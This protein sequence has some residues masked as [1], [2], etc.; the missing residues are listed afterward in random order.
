MRSSFFATLSVLVVLASAYPIVEPHSSLVPNTVRLSEGISTR[1]GPLSNSKI[2]RGLL[3]DFTDDRKHE[4]INVEGEFHDV[5]ENIKFDL[6]TK[7]TRG[8]FDD[9]KD[10]AEDL[11]EKTKDGVDQVEEGIKNELGVRRA[12]NS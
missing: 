6:V 5:P 7:K 2:R 10:N 11:W 8:F 1:S 9:I 4:W 3:G 12:R